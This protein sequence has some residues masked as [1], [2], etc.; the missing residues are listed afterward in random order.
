MDQPGSPNEDIAATLRRR[1]A[2]L[3]QQHHAEQRV[4]Q[5]FVHM[6]L[7]LRDELS[8]SGFARATPYRVQGD[9]EI[10]PAL[11]LNLIVLSRAVATGTPWRRSEWWDLVIGEHLRPAIVHLESDHNFPRDDYKLIRSSQEE[12]VGLSEVMANRRQFGLDPQVMIV[13]LQREIMRY[14]VAG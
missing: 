2:E 4:T 12:I 13:N 5:R 6:V 9:S 3:E 8:R 7:E 10:G 14:R 1:R 11:E